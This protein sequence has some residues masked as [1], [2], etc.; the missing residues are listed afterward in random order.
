MKKVKEGRHEMDEVM[1]VLHWCIGTREWQG[2]HF[3]R[4]KEQAIWAKTP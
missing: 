1:W 3:V 4:L 2:A